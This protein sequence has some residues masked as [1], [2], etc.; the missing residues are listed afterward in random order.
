VHPDGSIYGDADYLS[1]P[2]CVGYV[3]SLHAEGPVVTSVRVKEGNYM[4]DFHTSSRGF[5]ENLKITKHGNKWH[6]NIEVY[7]RTG[8]VL[9]K[10]PS[11]QENNWTI[12]NLLRLKRL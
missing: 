3:P 6:Q 4:V 5:R 12:K 11:Q 1:I 7:D 8:N 2:N 9:Y 10:F